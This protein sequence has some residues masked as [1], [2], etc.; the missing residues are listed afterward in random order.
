MVLTIK[1]VGALRHITGKTKLTIDFE[2]EISVKELLVQISKQTP[3]LETSFGDTQAG[4]L[5]SNA[6]ILVNGREIGVL[7]GSETMLCDGDEVVFVPIVH[8]G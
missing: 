1:F 8:G 3:K 6:L 5:M 4:D 2:K 7:G